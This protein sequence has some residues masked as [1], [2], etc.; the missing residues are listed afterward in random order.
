MGKLK[1]SYIEEKDLD[2]IYR[3]Y[4]HFATFERMEDYHTA[5]PD[6]IRKMVFEEKLLH[7]LKAE[8]DGEIVGFCTCKKCL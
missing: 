2:L 7:I 4:K 1:V 3:L 8:I 5:S 6:E